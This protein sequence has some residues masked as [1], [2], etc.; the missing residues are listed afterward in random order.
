MLV[1]DVFTQ[2]STVKAPAPKLPSVELVAVT[3]LFMPLKLSP[4]PKRLGCALS[5]S[6]TTG[7]TV[8]VVAA[9]VL[10]HPFALVTATV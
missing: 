3:L 8:T 2:S 4:Y 7:S 9:A 6:T 5:A 1:E 10:A